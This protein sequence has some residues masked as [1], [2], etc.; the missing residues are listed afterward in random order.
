MV[1]KCYEVSSVPNKFKKRRR[2]FSAE[3]TA[4]PLTAIIAQVS[5]ARQ[6]RPG[7]EGE[8]SVPAGEGGGAAV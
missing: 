8:R 4:P 5:P 2:C 6:K 7:G 3:W 1:D